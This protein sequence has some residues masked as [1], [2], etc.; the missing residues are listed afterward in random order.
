ME[1]TSICIE[2]I[3]KQKAEAYLSHNHS[4]RLIQRIR[5]E[6]YKRDMV[7]GMWQFTGESI[8][9]Y[10]NGELKD[11]QH[12]L[13]AIVETGIPQAFVV[14]RGIPVE[15][16]IADKN[17]PRSTKQIAEI[18]GYDAEL[19]NNDVISA[20]KFLYLA[21]RGK[22]NPSDMEVFSF[23]DKYGERLVS[24]RKVV[25]KGST[26]PIAKKAAVIAGAFVALTQSVTLETLEQFFE[27]VNSG[28]CDSQEQSA[29]IVL[30][31]SLENYN[32]S[33]QDRTYAFFSTIYAISDFCSGVP[34][35]KAYKRYFNHPWYD[36]VKEEIFQ[37]WGM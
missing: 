36:S 33:K 20:F 23:L 5:V 21:F 24:A 15:N 35:R 16:V 30:R 4:N 6:Q 25:Q 14:V 27:V 19:R 18:A 12:R 7:A 31:K 22:N 10:K 1:D 9:F 17:Q 32:R 34:R 3:D 13:T 29:A 37:K 26:N 11:G 28:F 2:V 8:S